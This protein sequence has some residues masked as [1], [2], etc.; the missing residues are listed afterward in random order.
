MVVIKRVDYYILNAKNL[1]LFLFPFFW[2]K[3]GHFK[4]ISSD[5][6]TK[7]CESVQIMFVKPMLM[8][9]ED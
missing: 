4:F 7:H 2:F 3:M 5:R 8:L 9:I 6:E 1:A